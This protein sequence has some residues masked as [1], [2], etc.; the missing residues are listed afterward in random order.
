MERSV[1]LDAVI[2]LRRRI[3]L[4]VAHPVWGPVVIVLIAIVLAL[5][6]IHVA[7]DDSGVAADIGAICFGI[8]T[9]LGAVLR[10]RLRLEMPV[11]VTMM[12]KERAP[13]PVVAGA[14]LR[15][16][17]ERAADFVLPLRR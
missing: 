2:E 17:Y 13:P 6:F 16:C 15:P 14:S 10:K 8:V 5:V 11:L 3:E 9:A 12:P 1:P 4:A 7:Q